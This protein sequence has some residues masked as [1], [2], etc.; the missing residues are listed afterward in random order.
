ML[1][2]IVAGV[3]AAGIV[4]S[5]AVCC[6]VDAA[7]RL[8]KPLFFHHYITY[9][10]TDAYCCTVERPDILPDS[11][12]LFLGDDARYF[13]VAA[14]IN[15]RHAFTVESAEID[16]GQYG[17]YTLRVLGQIYDYENECDMRHTD[18]Q[19]TPIL[20]PRFK[21]GATAL[22]FELQDL[23]TLAG[24][25]DGGGSV[26]V[27]QLLVRY[28]YDGVTCEEIIPFQ[29][30]LFAGTSQIGLLTDTGVGPELQ[31]SYNYRYKYKSG[32]WY[33]SLNPGCSIHNTLLPFAQEL[34][35]VLTI[36]QQSVIPCSESDYENLPEGSFFTTFYA[37]QA[38]LYC[39][40][41]HLLIEGS[42]AQGNVIS[43]FSTERV[44]HLSNTPRNVINELQNS[45]EGGAV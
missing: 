43:A 23:K 31:S 38:G 1:K 9:N 37:K 10:I 4:I 26:T 2:K 7:R 3:C 45:R 41:L 42:D 40:Q 6:G 24:L 39:V 17:V 30:I 14:A 11:L 44:C 21:T 33:Y 36:T 15:T 34:Q 18:A 16:L 27:E 25:L 13:P 5:C 20:D 29:M 19:Q 8:D 22:A 35:H 28:T 12:D 32:A